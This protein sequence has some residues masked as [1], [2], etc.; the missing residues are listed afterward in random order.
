[1]TSSGP[2]EGKTTTAAD[3]AVALAQAGKRVIL[4]DTDL[5]RPTLHKLFGVSNRLGVST[6]LLQENLSGWPARSSKPASRTCSCCRA[7]RCHPT[8]RTCSS[9]RR[10]SPS[11]RSLRH[12]PTSSCLT[13]RPC[14]P[15]PSHLAGAA[16][17]R[18]AARGAV[19]PRRAPVLKQAYERLHQS[20][21]GLMGTV[22]NRVDA[23]RNGYYKSYYYYSSTAE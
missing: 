19:R 3:L 21:A 23:S 15:S 9:R 5:R 12:W 8:R 2:V 22:L 16:V 17:R 1:M 18:R 11:S 6:A 7:G 10:W 20:G 4:V 13:A 14:W